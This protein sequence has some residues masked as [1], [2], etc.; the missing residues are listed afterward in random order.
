MSAWAAAGATPVQEELSLHPLSD[1]QVDAVV[2][3]EQ[4]AYSH[5]WT[6][7]NFMDSLRAG[8]HLRVLRGGDTLLGYY[9]A[10]A[11]VQEVHLLNI[12]VAP[13]YQRQ[14]HG[15]LLLDALHLWAQQ[16]QAQWIWLEV[17][18]GNAR[19]LQVYERYGY[20]R[21]GVRKAYYPDQ[22][23][24]REDAVVMSYPL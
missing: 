20:K 19:A 11:G 3:I 4:Q 18:A 10:M 16:Q 8:Y 1:D 7:G 13:A 17:R 24:R 15:R 14:G 9:V 21:V 5:P 23:H 2:L 6:R 12:T 22:L